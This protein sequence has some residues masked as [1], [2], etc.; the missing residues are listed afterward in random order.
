MVMR[1]S[2]RTSRTPLIVPTT[3]ARYTSTAVVALMASTWAVTRDTRMDT[4]R[5][6]QPKTF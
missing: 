3:L 2:H 6:K 4:L 1:S 5:W